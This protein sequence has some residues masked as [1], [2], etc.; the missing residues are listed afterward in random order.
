[1]HFMQ[2][3]TDTV[4]SSVATPA[5]KKSDQIAEAPSKPE[6]RQAVTA[7]AAPVSVSGTETEQNDVSPSANPIALGTTIRGRVKPSQDRDMFEFRTGPGTKIIRVILRKLSAAGFTARLAIYDAA[8]KKVSTG[9]EG[10][11]TPVS[12]SI[13]GAPNSDYYVAVKCEYDFMLCD[14][15]DYEVTVRAEEPNQGGN[16]EPN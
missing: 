9:W 11:D 13:E 10:S 14:H 6:E 3:A 5:P 4:A 16:T 2:K 15:T 12:L 7:S 8:E 1:M